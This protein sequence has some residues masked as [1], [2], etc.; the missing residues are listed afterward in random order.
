MLGK[1]K[2]FYTET[3]PNISPSKLHLLGATDQKASPHN[4]SPSKKTTHIRVEALASLHLQTK[5]KRPNLARTPQ[6][7]YSPSDSQW[8]FTFLTTRPMALDETTA[9]ALKERTRAKEMEELQKEV[10]RG[11]RGGVG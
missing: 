4:F 9:V 1:A 5:V 7:G 3:V 8:L 10:D 2:N 6:S 11:H